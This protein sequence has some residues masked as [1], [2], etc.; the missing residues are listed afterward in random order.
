MN[1]KE[2]LFIAIG[3][4]LTI[5]AWFIADLY[6]VST[7][8]KIKDKIEIPKI[9]NYQIKKDVLEIIENKKE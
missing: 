9:E 8:Q 6:H 4:F 2:I 1:K 3:I 7:E 5:I